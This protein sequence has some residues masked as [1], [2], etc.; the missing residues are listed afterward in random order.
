MN[1]TILQDKMT[2]RKTFIIFVVVLITLLAILIAIAITF[3]AAMS[4]GGK[5]AIQTPAIR[6]YWLF[7]LFLLSLVVST[8]AYAS[9]RWESQKSLIPFVA[10][11]GATLLTLPAYYFGSKYK[12]DIPFSFYLNDDRYE[13][14]WEFGPDANSDG[15]G[16]YIRIRTEYPGFSALVTQYDENG[17]ETVGAERFRILAARANSPDILCVGGVGCTSVV[18]QPRSVLPVSQQLRNLVTEHLKIVSGIEA[19]QQ[20]WVRENDKNTLYFYKS[21]PVVGQDIYGVCTFELDYNDC[22]YLFFDGQF[23]NNINF[24]C[25]SMSLATSFK[26]EKYIPSINSGI[27]N[28]FDS[29]KQ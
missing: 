12:V 14:P 8:L 24:Q 3:G 26:L 17:F 5:T 21:N 18:G 22:S 9:T 25:G 16:S 6:Y 1:W 4:W 29:F 15:R 23:Y 27:A 19:F 2:A 20:T 13:I 10:L 28:L 7:N 11:F